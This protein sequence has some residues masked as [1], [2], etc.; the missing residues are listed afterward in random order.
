MQDTHVTG[1]GELVFPRWQFTSTN[2]PLPDLRTVLHAFPTSYRALDIHTI[3]TTPQ[4]DLGYQVPRDMLETNESLD[5]LLARMDEL[6][7]T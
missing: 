7:Y 1:R 5:V 6:C 2:T 4:E 3:M